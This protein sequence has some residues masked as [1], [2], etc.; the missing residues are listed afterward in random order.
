MLI[1]KQK[2]TEMY[3]TWL[4]YQVLQVASHVRGYKKT[5]WAKH[6][7]ARVTGFQ[8]TTSPSLHGLMLFAILLAL[9]A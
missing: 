8:S 3:N 6:W 1:M 9:K 4:W 7:K 5:G 2:I